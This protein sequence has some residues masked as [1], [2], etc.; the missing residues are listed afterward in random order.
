VLQPL[1]SA[2]LSAMSD[3]T[4][5]GSDGS[6]SDHVL[7]ASLRA[8]HEPP[9]SSAD[10]HM[11]GVQQRHRAAY[12]PDDAQLLSLEEADADDEI[13][14]DHS[15]ASSTVAHTRK[16]RRHDG[17]DSHPSAATG[18]V[19]GADDPDKIASLL[20]AAESDTHGQVEGIAVDASSD[21]THQ[22]HLHSLDSPSHAPASALHAHQS[23]LDA[24]EALRAAE[25]ELVGAT[26][27]KRPKHSTSTGGGGG[28]GEPESMFAPESFLASS[29]SSFATAPSSSAA[30][31]SFVFANAPASSAAASSF[32]FARTV[33]PAQSQA[34]LFSPFTVGPASVPFTMPLPMAMSVGVTM[35]TPLPRLVP[36]A[37]I[38]APLPQ[39]PSDSAATARARAAVT[40]GANVVGIPVCPAA[41]NMPGIVNI[42]GHRIKSRVCNRPGCNE[43]TESDRAR[44]EHMV[45]MHATSVPRTPRTSERVPLPAVFPLLTIVLLLR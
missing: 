12:H 10:V 16:R 4:R 21:E 38:P 17:M 7:F 9:S 13:E 27:T 11:D 3:A 22:Y 18:V 30:A 6:A 35:T 39:P 32:V 36:P 40:G 44:F 37:S 24:E 31:S 15:A 14:L 42:K 29:S 2:L 1:P 23:E 5:G 19:D 33:L 25:F 45:K 28:A 8:L 43:V 20:I 34:D 41:I 26:P